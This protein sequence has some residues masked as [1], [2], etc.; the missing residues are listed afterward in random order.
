[1]YGTVAGKFPVRPLPSPWSAGFWES[2]AGKTL[3]I[4]G[5]ADCGRLEH[6]PTVSCPSCGS[7]NREWRPVSGHGTIHSYTICAHA[8][9]PALESL[10][11]Y[12]VI[13]VDLDEGGRI[14]SSLVSDTEPPTGEWIDARVQ[15]DFVETDEII[16]PVFRLL[17]SE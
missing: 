9:H 4:Q 13:I 7:L 11:P 12:N 5:C 14:V 2:L 1:M 15:V 3:S 16:L 8:V 10:I 6:P 17:E